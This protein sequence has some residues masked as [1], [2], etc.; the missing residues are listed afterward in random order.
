M[1][2]SARVRLL[3]VPCLPIQQA[4]QKLSGALYPCERYLPVNRF[5][6]PSEP[7]VEGV[8]IRRVSARRIPALIESSRSSRKSTTARQ[9]S[10]YEEMCRFACLRCRVVSPIIRRGTPREQVR[11][12][13]GQGHLQG[14]KGIG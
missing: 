9:R 5:P 1:I 4:D 2:L 10:V 7:L 6:Q 8:L 14:D 13:G 11:Q 3:D 12:S